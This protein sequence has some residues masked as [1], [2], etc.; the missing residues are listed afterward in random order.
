MGFATITKMMVEMNQQLH[1]DTDYVK[2]YIIIILCK[3][4]VFEQCTINCLMKL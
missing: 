3:K 1:A 2:K 4:Y